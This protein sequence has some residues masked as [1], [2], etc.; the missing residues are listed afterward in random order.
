MGLC[1]LFD[2]EC[3]VY[4]KPNLAEPNAHITVILKVNDEW[5]LEYRK[6]EQLAAYVRQTNVRI[7]HNVQRHQPL[8]RNHM[9]QQR[10]KR[11]GAQSSRIDQRSSGSHEVTMWRQTVAIGC[12]TVGARKHQWT[13]G[14]LR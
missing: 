5:E 9:R 2:A 8:R 1:A 11:V 10:G 13:I 7:I 3:V 4:S 6:A 14:S 12:L